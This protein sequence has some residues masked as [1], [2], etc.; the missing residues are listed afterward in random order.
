MS[1]KYLGI[2]DKR[3]LIWFHYFLLVGIIFFTYWISSISGIMG[4]ISSSGIL[5]KSLGWI[6]LF[7]LYYFF[8]SIGDQLIH[9]ILGVD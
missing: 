6:L 8:I 7:I 4:L 5:I 9:F 1:K 3:P 2:L